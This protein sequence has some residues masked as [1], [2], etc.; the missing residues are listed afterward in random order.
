M[1][2]IKHF[3]HKLN[4]NLQAFPDAD[5][6]TGMTKREY[7]ATH[8]MAAFLI[9]ERLAWMKNLEVAN[10]VQILAEVAVSAADLLLKAL[11]GK[12]DDT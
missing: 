10:D 9:E 7:M 6:A 3:A 4:G 5:G 12:S 2:E 1:E 11:E 8:L